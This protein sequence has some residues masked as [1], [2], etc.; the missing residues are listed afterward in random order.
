MNVITRITDEAGT[1]SAEENVFCQLINRDISGAQCLDM[2]GEPGCFGCAST[3][4][5]CEVCS[6]RRVDVPAVGMCSR[7]IVAELEKEKHSPAPNANDKGTV[8]CQITKREI[9]VAMCFA[10][11]GDEQ[12]RGCSARS[13]LC[14]KCKQH[15][16]RFPR[17][18]LCL[19]CS[20]EEYGDGWNPSDV[21]TETNPEP[22]T[23]E[24]WDRGTLEKI[25]TE[26]SRSRSADPVSELVP[27]V[28][29]GGAV[30]S[31]LVIGADASALERHVLRDPR[32]QHWSA[33][34]IHDDGM[35][36]DTT[37]KI[38]CCSA[39]VKRRKSALLEKLVAMARADGR[40]IQF[41]AVPHQVR[42]REVLRDELKYKPQP[43]R[44]PDQ[45]GIHPPI[46]DQNI[47]R[48][49]AAPSSEPVSGPS[50]AERIDSA[51]KKIRE[52]YAELEKIATEVNDM[53]ARLK[54]LTPLEQAVLNVANEM[55][56][57]I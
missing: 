15:P 26:V 28:P 4:R 45:G 24:S 23:I 40:Q 19:A 1:G 52:G 57:K 33:K 51:M 16:C 13:R 42:L 39:E 44:E 18:G 41:Y 32:I 20:V 5:R 48:S 8:S 36:P 22:P 46:T 27:L 9:R 56:I 14:E 38:V 3:S 49:D 6:L 35:I 2:Q 25:A 34:D 11:Q 10:T 7:C 21:S 37:E 54:L 47:P 50:I 30:A 17:Y 12:C 55:E 43:S 29:D 31:V 53:D